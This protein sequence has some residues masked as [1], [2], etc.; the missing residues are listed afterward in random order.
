MKA[1]R[2]NAEHQRPVMNRG[3]GDLA[4]A[5]SSVRSL[6]AG[7]IEP[8]SVLTRNAGRGDKLSAGL[9]RQDCNAAHCRL[10][11]REPLTSLR[12]PCLA[13]A[14]ACSSFE[15]SKKRHGLP[16]GVPGA[17]VLLH[18][19]RSDPYPTWAERGGGRDDSIGI[20]TDGDYLY[21]A[22]AS[23][24]RWPGTIAATV[25]PHRP[26]AFAGIMEERNST[27]SVGEVWLAFLQ[28]SWH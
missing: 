5:I 15:R 6:C 26:A 2:K 19:G 18:P 14:S 20:A 21:F 4:A 3:H 22:T 9:V 8:S 24:R 7:R 13:F 1:M 10:G 12:Q 28:S 11:L 25:R 16:R 17:C 27:L 23:L